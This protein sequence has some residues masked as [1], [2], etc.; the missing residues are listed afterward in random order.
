MAVQVLSLMSG[1]FGT[2]P[3]T[4]PD[5]PNP[6]YTSPVGP[7][8]LTTIVKSIR[9]VNQ[10]SVARTVNLYLKRPSDSTNRYITPI[11]LTIPSGGMV[12]DDQEITMSSNDQLFYDTTATRI[13]FVVS[14]IQR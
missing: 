10:D 2:T 7:P 8:A 9:L 6:F 4:P 12:I 1:Q 13:D 5:A 14:G 3:G 11:N